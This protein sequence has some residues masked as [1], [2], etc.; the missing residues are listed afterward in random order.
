M[1]R[2]FPV[3]DYL[4]RRCL[5]IRQ[6]CPTLWWCNYLIPFDANVQPALVK[7]L[8]VEG[9]EAYKTRILTLVVLL[10]EGVRGWLVLRQVLV[11]PF[12]RLK[13]LYC[14]FCLTKKSIWWKTWY[15]QVHHKATP[16]ALS[17]KF[18]NEYKLF[19]KRNSGKP[20]LLNV[21]M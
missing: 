5:F 1:A 4:F 20:C 2:V 15:F 8:S 3:S 7:K 14:Y 21:I 19:C 16:S 6:K 18:V 12:A 13:V 17:W 9:W 10:G 11:H